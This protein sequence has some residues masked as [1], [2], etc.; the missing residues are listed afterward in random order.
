V[1]KTHPTHNA[2]APPRPIRCYD[3]A[4]HPLAVLGVSGVQCASAAA[5]CADKG[6]TCNCTGMTDDHEHTARYGTGA[7]WI[8]AKTNSAGT[9]EC[10]L[11]GFGRD[12]KETFALTT[13][14]ETCQCLP[15]PDYGKPEGLFDI[16]YLLLE[17]R[18]SEPGPRPYKR[19]RFFDL[20][21]TYFA[22]PAGKTYDVLDPNRISQGS[23][24]GPSISLF[25]NLYHQHCVDF[26][27]IYAFE[28][29]PLNATDWWSTVPSFLRH[30]IRFYNTYVEELPDKQSVA[31]KDLAPEG[32]FLR[33]L[34]Q[35][36]SEE[37]FV[38]VKL[39]IDGG[40]ELEIAHALAARPELAK[41]VDEICTGSDT[42]SG[43]TRHLHLELACVCHAIPPPPSSNAPCPPPS[44]CRRR[45]RQ[46]PAHRS[47]HL[48]T[49]PMCVRAILAFSVDFEYHFFYDGLNFGW[50]DHIVKNSSVDTAI[51]L[52]QQFRRLG[53][54]SHFWI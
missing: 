13:Q 24:Y 7:T 29:R 2:V 44:H 27:D 8:E 30:R 48:L 49:C 3:Q 25:Y 22:E 10:T 19:A 42:L 18:C 23:G 5:H 37:D 33:M 21:C 54:R 46:F 39:D 15:A 6:E 14:S 51:A 45:C 26:D 53:I 52:M 32:S 20:G 40:P 43:Q 4:R 36:V 50:G 41:L 28:G 38:V 34:P 16:T 17:N 47:A 1:Q 11:P 35:A 12:V 31:G 9:I